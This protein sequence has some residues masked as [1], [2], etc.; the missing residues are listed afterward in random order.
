MLSIKPGRMSLV[1]HEPGAVFLFE[2][3]DFAQRRG[4]AVHRENAFG[5]D[6]Y[7]SAILGG[8]GPFQFF[9]EVIRIVMGK[10]PDFST[11][12]PGGIHNAG[13]NQFVQDDDVMLAEQGAD[14]SQR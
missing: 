13:V 12:E 5:R 7:L 9:R 14:S 3:D 6:K 10:N 2:R 11:A 1:H 8:G 4:I